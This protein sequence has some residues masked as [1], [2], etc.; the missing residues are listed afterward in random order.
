MLLAKKPAS[1]APLRGLLLHM[2]DTPIRCVYIRERT[3][4]WGERVARTAGIQFV[5]SRTRLPIANRDRQRVEPCRGTV[6]P[7][8]VG[9]LGE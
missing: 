9:G 7:S 2:M 3:T 4:W 1:G 6:F 8:T 5:V